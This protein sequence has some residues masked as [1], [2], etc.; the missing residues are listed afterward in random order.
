MLTDT[1][2]WVTDCRSWQGCIVADHLG[3]RVRVHNSVVSGRTI[4]SIGDVKFLL[5][6]VQKLIA[7]IIIMHTLSL[8][9]MYRM[10]QNSNIMFD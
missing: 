2:V 3:G 8:W 10:N 4:Q 5:Q 9:Y 6:I 1:A 7:I